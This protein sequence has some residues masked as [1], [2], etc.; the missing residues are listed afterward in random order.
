MG[1]GIFPCFFAFWRGRVSLN[2]FL[3]LHTYI[4]SDLLK[5]AV[6]LFHS[7]LDFLLL[8]PTQQVWTTQPKSISPLQTW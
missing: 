8:L 1:N 6:F 7:V 5:D 4:V 2:E 3:S